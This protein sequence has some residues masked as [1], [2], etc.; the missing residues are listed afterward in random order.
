MMDDGLKTLFALYRDG[1][2]VSPEE[3][4]RAKEQ[5]YLFD[6]PQYQTHEDALR[7]VRTVLSQIDPKDVANA[8][9]FSLSTRRLEY[10]SALGSYYFAAAVP[11]HEFYN[12][13]NEFLAKQAV[14]CY[15]CGWNAWK[16]VP[17]EFDLKYGHTF[18]NHERFRDG[19][20]KIGDLH[21]N[22]ALFDLQ[23][24]LKLPKVTPSE[25]DK[26]IFAGMLSCVARLAPSDKVGRLRDVISKAKLCKSNKDELLVLLGALGICGI[27]ASKE[28]PA[29]DVYFAD[30]YQRD[31]PESRSYFPYPVNRWHARDGIN[32]ER[33]LRVFGEDF[34]EY[35][36]DERN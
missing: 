7:E 9:L 30:E 24:F 2:S 8:F 5:G 12:S 26:R 6:Y 14:H 29:F 4:A 22:Y 21:I 27:L 35:M 34:S 23:Q 1:S 10:R 32:T 31:P 25:E 11:A 19:G 28:A 18:Y 20:S 36:T 3:I 33:L 16:Q 15:F 17:S 13:H